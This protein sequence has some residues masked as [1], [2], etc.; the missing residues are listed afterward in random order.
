MNQALLNFAEAHENIDFSFN[1]KCID[2]DLSTATLKLQNLE[3]D[4]IYQVQAD[5]IFAA[6]GAF[7]PVRRKM[8]RLKCFNYSQEYWQ[9]G[10]KEIIIPPSN[11]GNWPLEENT[12]HIWPRDDFMLIGFPI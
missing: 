3:T 7:S 12:I 4:E 10:Y 6:D 2:V 8:Q 1:Q 5:R 11:D 9:Q